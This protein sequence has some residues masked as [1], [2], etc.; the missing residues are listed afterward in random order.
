M[1]FEKWG[2]KIEKYLGFCGFELI[3]EKKETIW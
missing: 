1:W 3:K 2:L